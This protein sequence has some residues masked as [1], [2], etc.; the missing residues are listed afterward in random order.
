MR[1]HAVYS[2][3][4]GVGKTAGAVNLAWLSAVDGNRTL[5]WDL[6]PQGAASYYFRAEPREKKGGKH[7][8]E[9]RLAIDELIRGTEHDLLDV[10]P[11]DL[12][13]R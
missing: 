4:G 11:A 5:L 12:S 8:L 6:D 9:G 7:L 2:I 1:V 10:V 13:C 3:K